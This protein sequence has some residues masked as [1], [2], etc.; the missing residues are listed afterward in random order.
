MNPKSDTRP[1]WSLII[2]GSAYL[3]FIGYVIYCLFF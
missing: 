1:N 2:F 3:I